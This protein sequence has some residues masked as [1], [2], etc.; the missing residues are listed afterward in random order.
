ML[1][2]GGFCG[3]DKVTTKADMQARHKGKSRVK[4]WCLV[5]RRR[6]VTISVVA[7]HRVSRPPREEKLLQPHPPRR[8]LRRCHSPSLIT[9]SD[10][11]IPQVLSSRASRIV[12]L[13]PYCT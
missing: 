3:R 2:A 9:P 11:R 8:R 1:P 12:S 13:F 10:I 6:R 4:E 7:S 5:R